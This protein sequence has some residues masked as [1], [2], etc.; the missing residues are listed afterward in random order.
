M[1]SPLLLSAL[2]ALAVAGVA[3]D[4]LLARQ[5]A[6]R[7]P[8]PDR[9]V[10]LGGIR[11]H[12]ALRGDW[13]QPGPVAVLDAGAG[14]WSTHWGRTAE[15][16]G[17]TCPV[18]Q[19]DR[20]GLGWSGQDPT[21]HGLEDSCVLLHQ[22]LGAAA[23]GRPVVLV[24][25][26]DAALRA[27]LFARRYPH[28]VVGLVLIDPPALGDDPAPAAERPGAGH[29]L[30]PL[31]AAAGWAR[32]LLP[33]AVVPRDLA[34]H[35]SAH[36]QRLIAVLGRRPRALAA[37]RAEQSRDE[38]PGAAAR[39]LACPT[40]LLHGRRG[41]EAARRAASALEAQ[42]RAVDCGTRPHLVRPEVLADAVT[43][44]LAR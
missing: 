16:L 41:E 31:L 37:A 7:F 19:Y 32:W 23:P 4:R 33:R 34:E 35:L 8:P 15:L 43:A 42:V 18:L 9:Q 13:Q 27:L 21:P 28:E 12:Y 17:R 5:E 30:L 39:P 1:A 24:A 36:E 44:I 2:P 38:A 11:V 10:V 29:A 14:E 25:E 20:A 3:L 40:A 6:R 26:R 22:L